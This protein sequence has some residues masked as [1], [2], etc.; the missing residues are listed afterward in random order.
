L[1]DDI[2]KSP[3]PGYK[4]SGYSILGESPKNVE[5]AVSFKLIKKLIKKIKHIYDHSSKEM[6]PVIKGQSTSFF[7]E[8]EVNR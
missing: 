6:F 3:I 7:Q 4:F 5:I 2:Y 8:W 1:I